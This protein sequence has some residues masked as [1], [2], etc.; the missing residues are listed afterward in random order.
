MVHIPTLLTVIWFTARSIVL[1]TASSLVIR[2]TPGASYLQELSDTHE[3]PHRFNEEWVAGQAL[4]HPVDTHK[5]L[6]PSTA[7]TVG[8]YQ[9]SGPPAF[10]HYDD[11][12]AEFGD[13]LGSK[14]K[15]VN[16]DTMYYTLNNFY[17]LPEEKRME[18]WKRLPK[19]IK[20]KWK[21]FCNEF[22]TH[23]RELI[24][25]SSSTSATGGKELSTTVAVGLYEHSGP[26][27]TVFNYDTVKE[28][29]GSNIGS[30]K[31]ERKNV[32]PQILYHSYNKFWGLTPKER[33]K[34]WAALPDPIKQKWKDLSNDFSTHNRALRD[35]DS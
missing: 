16:A 23:T 4:A 15:S 17:G 26:P 35:I 32:T 33:M 24:N 27:E 29:L 3:S 5:I 14:Q 20:K 11:I 18:K 28:K 1:P 19:P 2:T 12:K 22:N 31:L 7:A 6:V 34:K 13:N 21:D 8:L 9:N 10:K 25:Q 30:N